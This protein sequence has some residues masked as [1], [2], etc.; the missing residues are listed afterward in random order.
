ILQSPP[1]TG[2]DQA[3]KLANTAAVPVVVSGKTP[4]ALKAAARN[5]ARVLQGQ[6][7][8]ALYDVAYH[9][10]MRREWHAER[11]VVYGTDSEAVAQAFTQCAEGEAPSYSVSTGSAVPHAQGPVCVYSGNGS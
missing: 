6:P 5:L 4:D 9:A 7:A 3:D 8:R 10:A 2:E 1:V 11:A